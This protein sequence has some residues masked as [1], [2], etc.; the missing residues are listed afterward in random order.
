VGGAGSLGGGE[1]LEHFPETARRVI[2][3]TRSSSKQSSRT[4]AFAETG[5]WLARGVRAPRARLGG[6]ARAPGRALARHTHWRGVAR[7]QRATRRNGSAK[8]TDFLRRDGCRP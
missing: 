8:L 2:A 5:I 4:T 7:S 3:T 1:K 6:A